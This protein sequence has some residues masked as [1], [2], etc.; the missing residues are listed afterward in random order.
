MNEVVLDDGLEAEVV[1]KSMMKEG[2]ETDGEKFIYYRQGAGSDCCKRRQERDN[3]RLRR[4]AR[5]G[6]T[7]WEE[8]ARRTMLRREA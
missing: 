4:G 2:E 3:G 8:G 7:I 1:V 6:P 5:W